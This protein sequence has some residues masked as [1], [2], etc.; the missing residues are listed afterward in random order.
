MCESGDCC[1]VALLCGGT[2]GAAPMRCCFPSDLM[3]REVKEAGKV[4]YVRRADI[5][6]LVKPG[7]GGRILV[8]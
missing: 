4:W 2:V 6:E 8:L 7:K 5:W 1:G 3:G